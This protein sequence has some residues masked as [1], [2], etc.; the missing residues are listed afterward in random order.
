M[1][2]Q[3]NYSINGDYPS[4]IQMMVTETTKC[5]SCGKILGYSQRKEGRRNRGYCNLFCL[6]NKPPKMAYVEMTYGKPAKDII[7]EILNNGTT[8]MATAERLGV[9]KQAL[10][11]WLDKLNIRK[12]VVWG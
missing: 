7:L 10:Y 1:K 4:E 3:A 8:M 9:N 2:K 12:K 11:A 5:L 6:S